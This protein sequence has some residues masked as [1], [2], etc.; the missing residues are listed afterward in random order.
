MPLTLIVTSAANIPPYAVGG[1]LL[2][3]GALMV[4]NVAKIPWDR[5]GQVLYRRITLFASVHQYLAHVT[6]RPRLL[7]S[8]CWFARSCG[9]SSA[10]CRPAFWVALS[11]QMLAKVDGP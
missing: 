10:H 1:A 3:V 6:G 5:I 9:R 7:Q 4:A 8:L 11:A 2:I